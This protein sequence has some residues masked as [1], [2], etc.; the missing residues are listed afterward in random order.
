MLDKF[1]YVRQGKTTIAIGHRPKV[2]ER[3]DWI[4]MLDKGELK[5]QGTP[6]E[7]RYILGDRLDFL[8]SAFNMRNGRIS[9]LLTYSINL[10]GFYN[11]RLA[12]ASNRS[13]SRSFV[14]L[15]DFNL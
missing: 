8:D 5:I 3:A 14:S 10:I 13:F 4:V 1:L 12:K 11:L 7:L 2:I 9:N 6:D 15:S